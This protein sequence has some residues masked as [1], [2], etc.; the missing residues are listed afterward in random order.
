MQRSRRTFRGISR[1]TQSILQILSAISRKIA[2]IRRFS[3]VSRGTLSAFVFSPHCINRYPAP[4]Y[5]F[6]LAAYKELII[7]LSQAN[8]SKV[9]FSSKIK[10][11]IGGFT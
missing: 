7:I 6:K 8:Q 5:G 9:G 4:R 11:K 3:D 1:E 2:L 10:R